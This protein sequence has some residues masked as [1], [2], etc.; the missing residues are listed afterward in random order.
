MQRPNPGELLAGLRLALECDVLPA[1][2]RGVPQQQLKAALH[3]V[4]RLERSWDLMPCH[5]EEDSADIAS[6]LAA[7]LPDAGTG[8]LEARLAQ[9]EVAPPAGFN[10]PALA[11]IARRNLALHQI[12]LEQDDTPELIALYRRMASRD[13]RFVGDTVASEEGGQ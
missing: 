8:S 2:P 4:K 3:L 1:L 12:L 6:A 9:I 10:D 5:L 11:E 7:L 13:A